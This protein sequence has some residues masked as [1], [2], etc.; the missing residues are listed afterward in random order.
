[1]GRG[2][3]PRPGA[4]VATLVFACALASVFHGYLGADL[5]R[6]A[7]TVEGESAD[8]SD[9]AQPLLETDQRFV[10]W[11]VARNAWTLLHRPLDLFDAEPC[12]PER[13]TLSL[14]EPG[15][16]LGI[17]G[18]PAWLATGDPVAT[19]DL[20]VM[21]LSLIAAVSMFWLVRDWTG[22]TGAGIAA[23]ILFGFHHVKLGEVVHP[24]VFDNAWTALALLFAVRF[25]EGRR[26]RDAL[27]LAAACSVQLAGS[28]YPTLAAA[29]LAL[30]FVAWLAWRNGLRGQR[31]LPWL[32][33]AALVAGVAAFVFAPYLARR[34]EGVLAPR[35]FQIFLPWRALLPGGRSFPGFVLLGLAAFGALFGH[36]RF[37]GS[38][39]R[40]VRWPLLAGALFAL[41]L[42]TGGNRPDAAVSDQPLPRLLPNPYAWLATVVPGLETIRGPYTLYSATQLVLCILAGLGCARL[43]RAAPKGTGAAAAAVVV[44]L[45]AHLDT[46]RP[47]SLGFEPRLRYRMVDRAPAEETVAFYRALEER[48]DRGPVAEAPLGK[49]GLRQRSL[50]V[51]LSAYHHRRTWACLPS[52]RPPSTHRVV[53]LLRA[54]P[55][56]SAVR[57]LADLGFATLVVHHGRERPLSEPLRRAFESLAD[58]PDP[59]LARIHATEDISAYSLREPRPPPPEATGDRDPAALTPASRRP[60]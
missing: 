20:V 1:M 6:S 43:V 10:I 55:H 30:P 47:A 2:W 15:I 29:C 38:L 56:R 52:Y 16:S 39:A 48:G 33:A 45:A 22:V 21:A 7:P 17:V 12:Y 35:T 19:Y 57:E 9:P 13:D 27:G 50:G 26:W 18:I 53:D 37:R 31:P 49:P 24:Y 3:V 54:V 59:L 46:L 8:P 51:L 36:S 14:G 42:A 60:R 28:L 44:V 23:G 11:L 34:A 40:D 41:A 58:G 4:G 25:W 32:V 5:R